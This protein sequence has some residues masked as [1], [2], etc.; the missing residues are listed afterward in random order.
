MEFELIVY[1]CKSAI[2]GK[3][4]KKFSFTQID[5]DRFLKLAIRN[6][7]RPLV[8]FGICETQSKR[9]IP[10][11]VF[12]RL[13]SYAI[14]NALTSLKHEKE[15]IKIMDS[16]LKNEIRAIPYKGITLAKEV[17][18]NLASREF[19]DI[20]ILISI[21]DLESLGNILTKKGY[22]PE[23]QFPE[24]YWST[25]KND[26]CEYNYDF[27]QE[28][29]RIFHLEPHWSI[30]KRLHQLQFGLDDF[31]EFI[32]E[33]NTENNPV[34]K[35]T[36]EGIF[37]TTCLHH[38]AKE[39][40]F[41]LKHASDLACILSK[42]NSSSWEKI[43]KK[44][45]KL[46]IQ[47]IILLGIAIPYKLFQMDLPSEII[48]QIETEK[49]GRL[50]KRFENALIEEDYSELTT[51]IYFENLLFHILLRKKWTTKFKIIYYHIVQILTPN[52]G[53]LA[54]DTSTKWQ[55]FLLFFKKPFR[56]IR[57]YFGRN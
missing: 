19:S 51:K 55:Y 15:L 16:L 1:F 40:R 57:T 52:I 42:F 8:Y 49:I 47:N 29:K 21:D 3:T 13:K 54:N 41:A 43:I 7:V 44:S 37:I 38:I 5:W 35:L 30:G 18:D 46:D 28:G 50:H 23:L 11:M 9:R 24:F 26:S 10:E 31:K 53:D 39:E 27:I 36:I 2:L 4:D 45:R 32:K 14:R 6:R 56:L 34:T 48:L 22:Q 20:D 17:Y 25:Y 33:A 12:D